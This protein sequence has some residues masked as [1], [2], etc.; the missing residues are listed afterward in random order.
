M[1]IIRAD[2]RTGYMHADAEDLDRKLRDGDGVMWAGDPRLYLSMGIV[3][4][5]KFHWSDELKRNVHK[6]EIVARRYEVWRFSEDGGSELIGTWR[7]EDFD[8]ILFDLAPL[9]L[10]SPGHVDAIEQIDAH[11]N[12]LEKERS[13]VLKG[14]LFETLEH[15]IKLWHDTHNPKN[16][17]RG[18]PGRRDEIKQE[19][20]DADQ[21]TS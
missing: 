21:S 18:I 3:E 15:Q 11:N 9:R 1:G 8:R 4:A 13:D 14:E 10:D 20:T 7:I 12:A 16:V 2:L 6:G 17:F 5:E 19:V